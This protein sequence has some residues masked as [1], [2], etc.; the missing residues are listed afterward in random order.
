[1]YP[2]GSLRLFLLS[3]ASTHPST[4]ANK[5][6]HTL[7][8]QLLNPSSTTFAIV[9]LYAGLFTLHNV[10]V[11]KTVK[12]LAPT[13]FGLVVFTCLHKVCKLTRT[14][15]S[16]L[17][18]AK[19]NCK[20][21]AHVAIPLVSLHFYQRYL[22]CFNTLC[23]KSC[24][25]CLH[26]S[27]TTPSTKTAN[28][29]PATEVRYHPRARFSTCEHLSYPTVHHTPAIRPSILLGFC[30]SQNDYLVTFLE[31]VLAIHSS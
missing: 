30:C 24:F 9:L 11:T 19:W 10:P 8:I 6:L 1:M 16:G 14:S 23:S 27:F 25:H 13:S 29:N 18:V 21:H 12:I 5:C 17:P 26:Y 4:T 28:L 20:G 2:N 3:H 7:T 31:I 15:S 22:S